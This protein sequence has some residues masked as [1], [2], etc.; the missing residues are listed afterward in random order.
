MFASLACSSG[1]F[2]L[3]MKMLYMAPVVKHR[4]VGGLLRWNVRVGK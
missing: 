3:A 2:D 1:N 4:Q